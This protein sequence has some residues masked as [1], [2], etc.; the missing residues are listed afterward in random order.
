MG[1]VRVALVADQLRTRPASGIATYTRGLLTGLRRLDDAVPA[2]T[3]VAGRP[4]GVDD[5]LA[6]WGWPV[7]SSRLPS[8]ALVRLW[9]RGVGRVDGGVDVVHAPSLASPPP[10]PAPLAVTVHDL[11]FREAPDTFPPRGR[12]WHEAALARA[13]RSAA[14]F[15]A[16][17]DR[18]A[19]LLT[20]AGAAPDRVTVINEGCD[21]LPVADAEG[22]AATLAA[23]G[24]HG[25][26]LLSVSTLEPRKNLA[27]L[28]QAYEQARPRLPEPWPMVVV[29]PPGWGPEL[30]PGPGAVL[31]GRVEPA[32]LAALYR[33][34][35][36]LVYVPLMEGFGLPAVEAMAAGI[37]VIASPMPSTGGA[38]GAV[39]PRDTDGIAE[40]IVA[41]AA[42]DGARARLVAAGNKRAAQLTWAGCARR[43]IEVWAAL[44]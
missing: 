42:D 17:S 10:G 11:A 29:G 9:D 21:H 32:T 16:P 6:A 20:S 43:H 41:V 27:R 35:R 15:V 14:A 5:P 28:L 25:P 30:R 13:L 38:A 23:I 22:A 1:D 31:A 7:Q 44:A 37:P 2:L 4:V 40:A 34:A 36:A 18:T 12:R 24:V 39:D 8:R 33:A 3:L 26:Y 19:A